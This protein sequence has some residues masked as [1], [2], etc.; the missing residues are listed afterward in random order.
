[1]QTGT[2]AQ[3]KLAVEKRLAEFREAIELVKRN[4]QQ[5]GIAMLRAP[6]AGA[7]TQRITE[8]TAAMRREEDHLFVARTV[9]AD[10]SQEL[11][12]LV[13]IAGSGLVVALAGF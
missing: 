2:G 5:G 8:L 11:A 12:S 1:M 10:R 3:L 7:T 6:D 4:D 9:S 13:T